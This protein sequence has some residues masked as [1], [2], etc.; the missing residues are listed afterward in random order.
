MPYT[1]CPG[2]RCCSE[3]SPL[4][5]ARAQL[6]AGHRCCPLLSPAPCPRHAP[7]GASPRKRPG[8]P[9]GGCA[10]VSVGVD[11]GRRRR[12]SNPV[13]CWFGVRGRG[14]ECHVTCVFHSPS[15]TARAR[16]GPAVSDAV[17]TQRGPSCRRPP[18]WAREAE[19]LAGLCCWPKGVIEPTAG[20][21][22]SSCAR[23]VVKPFGGRVGTRPPK[24]GSTRRGPSRSRRFRSRPREDRPGK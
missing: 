15:V 12:G 18:P 23:G 19:W 5:K 17:R 6:P 1:A 3:P 22:T 11:P 21:S 24:S 13:P 14:G 4:V 7:K 20:A 2:E 16:R 10:V 9:P 8:L